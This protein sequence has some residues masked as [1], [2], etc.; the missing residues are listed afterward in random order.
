[1]K[2]RGIEKR[3]YLMSKE[4]REKCLGA[5]SKYE[6]WFEGM[7]KSLEGVLLIY[8]QYPVRNEKSFYLIDYLANQNIGFEIDGPEHEPRKDLER[9]KYIF[10]KE[11]IQVY[12]F[13]NMDVSCDMKKVKKKVLN[14]L[15]GVNDAIYLKRLEDRERTLTANEKSAS[16]IKEK[17]ANEEQDDIDEKVYK[18]MLEENY[19]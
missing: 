18:M 7:L 8:P 11:K 17:L 19:V 13:T 3:L 5:R 12:R 10:A 6:Y 9:D 15:S 1:M 4:I 14:I 2:K 16:D